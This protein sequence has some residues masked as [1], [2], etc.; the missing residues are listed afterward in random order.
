MY[1][2]GDHFSFFVHFFLLLFTFT[3]NHWGKNGLFSFV[4]IESFQVPQLHLRLE[5]LVPRLV[6]RKVI[7]YKYIYKNKRNNII[8]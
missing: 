1:V 8:N 2:E 6:F 5:I 3:S 4:V 7:T